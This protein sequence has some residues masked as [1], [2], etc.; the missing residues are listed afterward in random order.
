MIKIVWKKGLL[1]FAHFAY[2]ATMMSTKGYFLGEYLS[3]GGVMRQN[4]YEYR[5]I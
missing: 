1:K 5:K 4:Y 3:L 2:L